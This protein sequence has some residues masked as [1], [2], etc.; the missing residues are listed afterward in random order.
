[1]QKIIV[2]VLF[3][4]LAVNAQAM[5]KTEKRVCKTKGWQSAILT[6]VVNGDWMMADLTVKTKK[7]RVKL[8]GVS[9]YANTCS[10]V[11]NSDY[12]REVGQGN[13]KIPVKV[14]LR[15]HY[16]KEGYDHGGF[17]ECYVKKMN[18]YNF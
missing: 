9:C 18:I 15:Y 16:N 17:Y 3:A 6:D 4:L 12:A 14:Q 1:M 8:G 7:G 11:N 5:T 10:A 2:G 13:M